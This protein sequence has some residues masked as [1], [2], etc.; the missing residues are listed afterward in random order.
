MFWSIDNIF[1]A[2]LHNIPKDVLFAWY[3][4]SYDKHIGNKV[5]EKPDTIVNL[6]S[7]ALGA[8]E[9]TDEEKAKDRANVDK[10]WNE[11]IDS[12]KK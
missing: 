8:I 1:E 7:F 11:L 9:Y 3:D 6:T 4:Y 5:K 12:M 10:Y 2:L